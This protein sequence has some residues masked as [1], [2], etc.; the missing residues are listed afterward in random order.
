MSHAYQ[1][2]SC[3][4]TCIS[5]DLSCSPSLFSSHACYLLEVLHQHMLDADLREVTLILES[6]VKEAIAKCETTP[7]FAA[8]VSGKLTSPLPLTYFPY[9][10]SFYPRP[11]IKIMAPHRREGVVPPPPPS[12]GDS[13]T[14]VGENSPFI[15]SPFT[16]G[17]KRGPKR[18]EVLWVVKNPAEMSLVI[19]NPLPFELRVENMV[20]QMCLQIS[21]SPLLCGF[22]L[23]R[24]WSWRVQRWKYFLLH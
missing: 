16:G 2:Q 24:L 7:S 17:S 13:L 10:R 18:K 14:E 19:A 23:C 1:D 3:D 21:H 9:V 8:S 12:S 11:L 6:V 22:V 5:C 20:I 15:Y 4:F